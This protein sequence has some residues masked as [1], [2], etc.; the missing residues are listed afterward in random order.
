[1]FRP[2]VPSARAGLRRLFRLLVGIVV[3]GAAAAA[4]MAGVV[5]VLFFA[6]ARVTRSVASTVRPSPVHL[7]PL[8]Q[9]SVV[10]G[11]DGSII[12]VL[13]SDSNRKPVRLDE[14]APVAVNAVVDTE[15]ARFWQHGGVDRRGV[16]RAFVTDVSTGNT[17][18]G[19][20][21]ITQQLVKNTL[22]TSKHELGRKVT[23]MVL[24]NRLERQLGKQGVLERYLNTIYF[25]EGAYGVEAAA[26]TYFN[27]ASSQLDPA[28]AAMLAGLIQDPSGYDPIHH[29]SAARA[30]RQTVLNLLVSHGH[31]SPAAAGA[32]GAAPLPTAPHVAPS[33]RDYVTDE[34]KHE[35][36]ADPRLGATVAARY[37]AIFTGGLQ[38]HTTIDPG[39]QAA[40]QAAIARGVPAGY[41]LTAAQISIDP[42]TGAISS[43]AGGADFTSLQFNAALTG[44]GR[45]PGS[46]FKVFTLIAALEQGFSPDDMIDG[47]TPCDIPNPQG[48]P[49]PWSPANFE[50]ETVGWMSITDATV[51]SVNCAYARLALMVGLG[52]I[53]DVAHRLGITAHLD[54]VPSMTLGTNVVTPLQMASAYA[55]IANDGAYH[56]PY[57]IASVADANGKSLF[58][59]LDKA[60]QAIS[61]QIAREATQ[62]LQQ[63]V[64][65]GTGVAA[66]VYGH[67]VAGKTGTAESY[68][69]AWFV[70][71]TPQLATAVWMGNVAG[72]VPMRNVAGIN[73][74]GG[75]FPARIW[76]AYMSAALAPL[77]SVPFVPPDPSQ[78]PA[79]VTLVDGQ[80]RA[81]SAGQDPALAAAMAGH[82]R[83]T[84]WCSASCGH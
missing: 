23:E 70:G 15:D 59:H 41:H 76:N 82:T 3:L 11:S 13:Q 63:V 48:T 18:Q 68:H 67:P 36:A 81:E 28:Q 80:T 7:P 38:I 62:V 56:T 83:G 17:R 72:E 77:R 40:A 35:R 64:F 43:V 21:S 33:G 31:L 50:G 1:V 66:G 58:S 52:R 71:Y 39:R 32:A 25:G 5:A 79:P 73:V 8:A 24:A 44:A 9:R 27:I 30:R 29:P 51:H 61:P 16:L 45:Q 60:R 78:I 47:S 69:D 6:G 37:Q 2:P 42:S 19:G 4:V 54:V 84:T 12:A 26:E 75:S 74:Q 34:V 55:T 53:A 57:L 49:N 22:L 65:R 10:Y 20:S 46:S 14:V